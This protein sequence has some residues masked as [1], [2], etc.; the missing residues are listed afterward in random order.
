MA[1]FGGGNPS[2]NS[3]SSNFTVSGLLELLEIKIFGEALGIGLR[4][5]AEFKFWLSKDVFL[6]L[7]KW[8]IF[9]TR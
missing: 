2:D 9:Y 3:D 4:I 5:E 7:K 6:I 8:G 1:K